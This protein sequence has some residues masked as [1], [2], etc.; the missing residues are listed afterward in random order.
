MTKNSTQE[1]QRIAWWGA[2]FLICLG[3]LMRFYNITADE[4]YLYDEGLYLTYNHLL[5]KLWKLHPPETWEQWQQAI[6]VW[7]QNI[8]LHWK[9]FRTE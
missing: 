9:I 7:F 5:L 3:V 4:F 8:I 6:L 2:L 1:F